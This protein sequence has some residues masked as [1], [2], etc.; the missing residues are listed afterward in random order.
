MRSM[1][2]RRLA[3]P[4]LTIRYTVKMSLI[5]A[6]PL[7]RQPALPSRPVARLCNSGHTADQGKQ[8]ANGSG[9]ER[10]RFRLDAGGLGAGNAVRRRI[11]TRAG[12]GRVYNRRCSEKHN[13][14]PG[15]AN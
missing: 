15:E 2:S 12:V 8:A 1:G 9:T 13:G 11:V 10:R 14:N 4:T 5:A 3:M 6:S 7:M